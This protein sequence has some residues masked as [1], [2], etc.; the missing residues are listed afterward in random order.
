MNLIR[1][2]SMLRNLCVLWPQNTP[3]TRRTSTNAK[4]RRVKGRLTV[5]KNSFQLSDGQPYAKWHLMNYGECAK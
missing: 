4:L 3:S 5:L 1:R 2:R